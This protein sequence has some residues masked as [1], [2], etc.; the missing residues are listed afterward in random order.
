M[1]GNNFDVLSACKKF[2]IKK[3]CSFVFTFTI[4]PHEKFWNS[5]VDHFNENQI[6]IMDLS[7]ETR[8]CHKNQCEF[9]V[10]I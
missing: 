7:K 9:I 4:P 5:Q 8:L 10:C 1:Q 2:L 3:M 6:S